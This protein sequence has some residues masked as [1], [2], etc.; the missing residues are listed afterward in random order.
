VLI[1]L[2]NFSSLKTNSLFQPLQ[3]EEFIDAVEYMRAPRW[4]FELIGYWGSVGAKDPTA[5]FASP[6]KPFNV[7]TEDSQEIYNK[8]YP[9]GYY[10]AYSS[11]SSSSSSSSNNNSSV[12]L[13]NVIFLILFFSVISSISTFFYLN[14]YYYNQYLAI[15]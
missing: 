8:K 14:R 11:S 5:K 1:I 7:P 12:T 2:F 3:L 9:N 6:I 13:F 4:W 10:K 15:K